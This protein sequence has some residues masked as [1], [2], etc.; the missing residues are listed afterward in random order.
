MLFKGI[1]NDVNLMERVFF[2]SSEVFLFCI[3]VRVYL[4]F[5]LTKGPYNKELL[6]NLTT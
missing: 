1:K 5:G 2:V 4:L 6:K 3:L